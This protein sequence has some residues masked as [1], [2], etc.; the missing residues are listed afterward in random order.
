M[1]AAIPKRLKKAVVSQYDSNDC[2]AACLLSI[3]KFYGINENLEILKAVS[4]TTKNG[5]TLLGLQ[6]AR[7]QEPIKTRHF[8][9]GCW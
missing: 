6:E 3:L 7:Y 2:G 8:A 4:G 1:Q 5:T 9:R